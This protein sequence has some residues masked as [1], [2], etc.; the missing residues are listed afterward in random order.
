MG[1]VENED[2]V[3]SII[4][5]ESG[6]VGTLE[7]SR[8]V[9]GPAMEMAFEVF[10]SRGSVRW[11]CE[12]MNEFELYLP[13]LATGGQRLHPRV[14][15]PGARAFRSLSTGPCLVYEFRRPQDL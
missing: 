10:G 11:N 4:N 3:G 5:F 2:Y 12:R 1:E 13:E 6:A 14:R 8:V 9:V 7:A 15:R